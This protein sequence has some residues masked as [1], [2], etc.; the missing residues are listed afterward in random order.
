[1]GFYRGP[2]I[3]TAGLKFAIDAGSERSFNVVPT[4]VEVLVIAGGGGG[5]VGSNAGGGGGAGGLLHNAAYSLSSTTS[6]AVTVGAGGAGKTGRGSGTNG[7]NSVFGTLT[8]VGG[9]RGGGH[10]QGGGSVSPNTG[11]SG[12]GGSYSTAGAAGTSGQ[13]FAG[14]TGA[15]NGSKPTPND[16]GGGGGGA[17]AVG[18]D[19]QGSG[20][21]GGNGGAG[22]TYSTSGFSTVYA[23]GGGGATNDS[24][25]MSVGGTGGGGAGGSNA[26]PNKSGIAG[27]V[28]SGSGGGGGNGGGGNSGAGGSGVVIIKYLGIQKA[29][30]G[31][32][33]TVNGY[34]IHTF[35]SS[36][37]FL[38]VDFV[39]NLVGTAD[40]TLLNGVGFSTAD[41]GRFD[42]DGTDEHIN[43][44]VGTGLNEF[45]TGDFAISVWVKRITGGGN[46]GTIIGDYLTTNPPT[47]GHWQ[48]MVGNTSQVLF[49]RVGSGSIIPATASG[50]SNGNWMNVVITRSGSTFSMYANSNLIAT[51]T[52]SLF[53]GTSS[54]N[55]NIGIDGNQASEAFT[56]EIAALQI[57]NDSALTAAQVLQNYNAQK[58]RFGL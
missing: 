33:T 2:N 24:S 15:Q 11:G 8:A 12:G 42:F 10:P 23:G 37:T 21:P 29:T 53:L 49:Y 25:S 40:G 47:T 27:L 35:T 57:R 39:K 56:G 52:N 58:S 5:G 44:G 55:L 20:G 43:I 54:G 28:N 26:D 32:I 38:L 30:G 1:M 46:F 14:G 16:G 19:A 31:T 18:V 9:G 3:V 4:A 45:G 34:T 6:F 50:V 41:G 51:N 36:G 48:L 22:A 17:G 13:G 7:A